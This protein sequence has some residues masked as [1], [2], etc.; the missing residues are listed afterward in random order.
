MSCMRIFKIRCNSQVID[1]ADKDAKEIN[2]GTELGCA[3]KN[4]RDNYVLI[5]IK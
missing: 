2:M 5:H 3:P 1:Y 4:T